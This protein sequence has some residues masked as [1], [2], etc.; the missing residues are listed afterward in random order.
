MLKNLLHW[1]FS[2]AGSG[3]D[4]FKLLSVGVAS[5]ERHA[6]DGH[7]G[8][9]AGDVVLDGVAGPGDAVAEAVRG[10]RELDRDEGAP[11]GF[12]GL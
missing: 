5:N 3:R 9:R 7:G 8:A 1:I 6:R 2:R 11:Q 10:H 4:P 12:V